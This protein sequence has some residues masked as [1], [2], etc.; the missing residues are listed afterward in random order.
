MQ[1]YI[2]SSEQTELTEVKL[3][4]NKKEVLLERCL[5]IFNKH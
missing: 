2:I 3:L 5:S 4:L 1:I